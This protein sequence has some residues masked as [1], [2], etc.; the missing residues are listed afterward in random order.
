M[1]RLVMI[2]HDAKLNHFASLPF[3]FRGFFLNRLTWRGLPGSCLPMLETLDLVRADIEQRIAHAAQDRRSPMHT[4][5]VA[6]GDADLRVMVV[7]GFDSASWTLRFHTDLRA[8]KVSVIEQDARVGVLFYDPAGRLQI[9]CTGSGR[10]ESEGRAVDEAWISS[11]NFARRCY[12]GDGPGAES[13]EA[14]SGL[15]PE[16]EGIKPSDEQLVPARENFAILLVEIEQ[17][18]W[19]SLDHNG[20]RRAIIEKGGAGRWVAP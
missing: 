4:A 18:D 12:L 1:Y 5:V 9:R 20:H 19:F 7:R 6:T 8:P 2:R 10:I 3:M 17:A 15:P 11:D 13:S 16:I 14:T